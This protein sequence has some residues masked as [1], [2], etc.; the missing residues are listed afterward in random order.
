MPNA[1]FKRV[2]QAWLDTTKSHVVSESVYEFDLDS[3]LLRI[4][5]K[6]FIF[7]NPSRKGGLSLPAGSHVIKRI[8]STAKEVKHSLFRLE[9]EFSPNN[10]I[11][12]TPA[13]Q[14][15]RLKHERKEGFV[16]LLINVSTIHRFD[17][18]ER[19]RIDLHYTVPLG[20]LG[21]FL[22]FSGAIQPSD[23]EVARNQLKVDSATKSVTLVV[24]RKA[25]FTAYTFDPAKMNYF[26]ESVPS[27][28]DETAQCHIVK[29]DL[30]TIMQNVGRAHYF[31]V[32]A[33]L[34]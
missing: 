33:D 2:K 30:N 7:V 13:E 20:E 22:L 21:R 11:K 26:P 23:Y 3:Q 8:R 17:P 10:V 12:G 32:A 15:A 25:P 24:R 27:T 1:M 5:D 19:Y 29:S 16:N 28:Y 6:D 9:K 14:D 31:T 34:S 18:G 4:Q